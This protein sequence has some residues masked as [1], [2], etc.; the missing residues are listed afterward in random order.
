MPPGK[1]RDRADDEEEEDIALMPPD[2]SK[3]IALGLKP[4]VAIDSSKP[5][6]TRSNSI[7]RGLSDL[8]IN[9]RY[10][11]N[12]AL[13][14]AD[15]KDFS[16]IAVFSREASENFG[17]NWKARMS[18]DTH[19]T[20]TKKSRKGFSVKDIG[21]LLSRQSKGTYGP[22]FKE[23]VQGLLENKTSPHVIAVIEGKQESDSFSLKTQ[24]D[25]KLIDVKYTRLDYAQ[26]FNSLGAK[27]NKQSMSIYVREDMTKV[28]SVSR[29]NIPHNNGEDISALGVNYSTTDGT[30]YRSLIVHIPNDFVGK[31]SLNKDTH[32]SFLNYATNAGKGPSPVVVTSYFGDTNYG[33]PASDFSSPSMGGHLPDGRTLNPQSSSAKKETHFMQ[34][35]ALRDGEKRHSVLQPSTLN[36]VFINPDKN[37]K[38]ATDHPSVMQYTAHSSVL[39]GRDFKNGASR[40][41][42]L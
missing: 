42:F 15:M 12:S 9:E 11:K 41:D 13:K 39:A 29:E 7:N 19:E 23:H 27:D 38:E 18:P 4:T 35:A 1:K 10:T 22:N 28:Y 40:L 25:G 21:R 34:S 5:R 2:S 20:A 8:A 32:N 33:S 16:T 6:L 26:G 3:K 17:R 24:L 36:Y 37:N 30:R 14:K 31:K